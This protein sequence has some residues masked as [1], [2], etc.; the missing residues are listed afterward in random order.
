MMRA[1]LGFL[2][3]VSTLLLM[4]PE[5]ERSPKKLKN[6]N[7]KE[8][9]ADYDRSIKEAEEA[10]AAET[11]AARRKLLTEL[12]TAQ[13]KA[14]K[15]N[16]LDDAVLIR[17]LRRAYEEGTDPAPEDGTLRIVSAFY[18][19]NVSWLDVTEKVRRAAKD[20]AKWSATVN[21]NDWGEPAPGFAG[22][23]TLIVRYA[24][25]DEVRFKAVYQGQKISIP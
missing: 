1:S 3:I 15:A 13:E 8:A 11:A 6:V 25:G 16:D 10:F 9:V 5:S 2:A 20:K 17:D 19:Q 21:T 14:A 23:R 22:P 24:E 18:G 4:P 7:A 12:E